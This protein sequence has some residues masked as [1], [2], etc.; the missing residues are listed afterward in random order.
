MGCPSGTHVQQGT[1]LARGK[2]NGATMKRAI[3]EEGTYRRSLFED[4]VAQIG[5]FNEDN[6]V[7]KCASQAG[8]R[9]RSRRCLLRSGGQ[10]AGED[11]KPS[12][13]VGARA[14]TTST[15]TT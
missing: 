4:W 9:S 11:K 3:E 2:A 10:K 5:R 12:R 15:T 13:T 14:R 6:P 7:D 1:A 8:Y